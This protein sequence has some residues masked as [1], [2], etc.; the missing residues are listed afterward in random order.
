[1]IG[2]IQIVVWIVF[3]AVT[4]LSFAYFMRMCELTEKSEDKD[5]PKKIIAVIEL[6]LLGLLTCG[7]Y[8][9]GKWL[10]GWF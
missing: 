4:L 6:M 2:L 8:T 7:V 9:F 10:D 1:M 3:G 5:F